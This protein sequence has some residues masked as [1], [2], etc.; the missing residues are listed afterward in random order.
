MPFAE[1]DPPADRAS[2][3]P[4]FRDREESEIRLYEPLSKACS[5][6]IEDAPAWK[7]YM[8]PERGDLEG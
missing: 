7:L 1:F 4:S 8:G 2:G 5:E 3:L 6:L